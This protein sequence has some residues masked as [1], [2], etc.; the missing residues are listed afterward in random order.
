MEVIDGYVKSLLAPQLR[1]LGLSPQQVGVV[2]GEVRERLQSLH[3]HW[4]DV[5][6]RQA[7]L[8]LGT[9]EA[10]FWE[11]QSASLDFRSLVVVAIRNSLITDLNA[12][13]AYTKALRS[14]REL[15]PDRRMPLITGEAIRY[16]HAADQ[17]GS[18]PQPKNDAFATSLA[19]SRT[20]GMSSPCSAIHP[21][22]R[23]LS[24]CHWPRPRLRSLPLANGPS[25]GIR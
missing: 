24:T 1:S 16:F 22:R 18:C 19:A 11:P 20:P 6:F 13:R 12:S 9:E 23:S 10:S 4:N 14:R 2:I 17:S 5:P 15:L 25:S 8:V 3:F 21:T 7:L